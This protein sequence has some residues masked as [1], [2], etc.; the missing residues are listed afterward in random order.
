MKTPRP[1]DY[2]QG[3]GELVRAYRYYVGLTPKAM[4]K[5]LSMSEPSLTDIET[6]RRACPAG[7]IDN[8]DKVATEFDDAVQGAIRN[9]ENLIGED[10]PCK[11]AGVDVDP[12]DEWQRAVIGR[13]AVESAMILPG[14]QPRAR[15]A[16]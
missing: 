8:L 15:T 14:L 10:N 1:A 3:Y 4:A 5:K 11:F 13:A 2:A 12:R 7:L 16:V 9:V 6:G